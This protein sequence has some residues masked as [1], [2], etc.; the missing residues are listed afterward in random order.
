[1]H[2]NQLQ[3]IENG[4][5][6]FIMCLENLILKIVYPYIVYY[7]LIDKS[8]V[9]FELFLVC[10]LNKQLLGYNCKDS[11]ILGYELCV[12]ELYKTIEYVV[13]TMPP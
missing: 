12:N 3:Y 4:C 10:K 9:N 1:M 8:P 13:L 2:F 11:M 7:P 6:F 5:R